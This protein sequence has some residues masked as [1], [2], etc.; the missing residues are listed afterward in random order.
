MPYQGDCLLDDVVD[1]ELDHLRG[2]L[3]GELANPSD[4]P[5]RAMGLA[6][7]LPDGVERLGY[8]R[9]LAVQPPQAGLA[10]GDDGRERLVHFM[11]DRR[12]HFP[13]SRHPSDVSELGLCDVQCLLRLP[14]RSDIHQRPDNFLLT[15]FVFQAM[16]PNLKV[17]DASIRRQ[18]TVFIVVILFALRRAIDFTSHELAV[19]RVNALKDYVDR[20]FDR[21]VDFQNPIGFVRPEHL[22]ARHLPAEAARDAQPLSLGQIGFAP[23]Q[24]AFGAL[25]ILDVVAHPIPFDHGSAVVMQRHAADPEPSIFS[26]GSPQALFHLE[27]FPRRQ[28]GAPRALDPHEV[29]GMDRNPPSLA[30]QAVLGKTGVVPPGLIDE[31]EGAVAPV[32]RGQRR[33]G[34][35]RHLKLSFGLATDLLGPPSFGVLDLQRRVESSSS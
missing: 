20:R 17:L 13:E 9:N 10:V 16:S 31:I 23:P 34:V 11:R 3:P 19:V 7:N 22:A 29:V 27:R 12:A 4:H 26:V 15:Q 21:A 32:A 18:Q 1:V 25:L 24:R 8:F 35:D 30:R 14:G 5:A 6:D 33:D 2:G 28:V